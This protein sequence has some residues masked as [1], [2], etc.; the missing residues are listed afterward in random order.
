MKLH[1]PEEPVYTISVAARLLGVH[2]QTLRLLEKEGL[3]E[4]A[5]TKKN[6]RLYS[7]NDLLLLRRIFELTRER[8]VNL[9]GVR[10]ILRL[11]I[12]QERVVRWEQKDV[13]DE[14]KEE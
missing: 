8:G 6:V 9:A 4:P 12:H 3:V 1:G 10:E 11:E 13:E 7:E 14:E 5:R 2:P